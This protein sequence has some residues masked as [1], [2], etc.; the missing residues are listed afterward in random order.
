[1]G[2]IKCESVYKGRWVLCKFDKLWRH[3]AECFTLLR[4]INIYNRAM[5]LS[6]YSRN[7]RGFHLL[8]HKYDLVIA[9]CI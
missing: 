4:L 9:T 8:Q 5:L 1:M 7:A 2:L 3:L 6:R